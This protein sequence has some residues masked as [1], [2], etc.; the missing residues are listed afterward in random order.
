[1][2]SRLLQHRRQVP[3]ILWQQLRFAAARCGIGLTRNE[4]FLS[5]L[6]DQYAGR[7]AFIIG[8]GPSLRMADLDALDGEICFGANRIYLAF[9]HTRWRPT[10]LAAEDPLMIRGSLEELAELELI[11]F[12]PED[13]R[14][15]FARWKSSTF[16]MLF[17]PYFH[18]SSPRFSRNILHRVYWGGTVVFS[19]MQLAWHMGIRELYL[20]GMDH[21][22]MMEEDGGHPQQAIQD[23]GEVN[24]FHPAYRKSGEF[25]YPPDVAWQEESFVV[26]RQVFEA[27]GGKIRNATRGGKLEV[28]ERVDFDALVSEER[29]S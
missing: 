17:L 24:H 21:S 13:A 7:R 15:Y 23:R 5:D 16:P 27:S 20:I 10:F 26:A 9:P 29:F 6:R 22:F 18:P 14:R 19:L 3:R 28:F 1:M 2:L 4:R 8:N 12:F 11:R 25:W